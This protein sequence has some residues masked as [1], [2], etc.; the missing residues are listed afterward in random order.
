MRT[1]NIW[2][3]SLFL[4]AVLFAT[5]GAS[6]ALA[7]CGDDGDDGGDGMMDAGLQFDAGE[8]DGGPPDTASVRVVHAA[9]GAGAV[10]LYLGGTTSEPLQ[11]GFDYRDVLGPIDAPRNLSV[12]VYPAGADAASMDPIFTLNATFAGGQSYTVVVRARDDGSLVAPSFLDSTIPDAASGEVAARFV[13]ATTPAEPFSVDTDFDGNSDTAETQ[14]GGAVDAIFA[15]DQRLL[16]VFDGSRPVRR[17]ANFL[18]DEGFLPGAGSV[19]FIGTGDPTALPES[20]EGFV[21]IY[22]DTETNE[23]QVLLPDVPRARIRVLHASANAPAV[24]VYPAGA[25]GGDPIIDDL[26]Y[27]FATGYLTVRTDVG[28]DIYPGDA[29]PGASEPILAVNAGGA[30]ILDRDEDYTLLAVG[31][32]AGDAPA[33]EAFRVIPVLDEFTSPGTTSFLARI[34][35]ASPQ[36]PTITIDTTGDTEPETDGLALFDSLDVPLPVDGVRATFLTADEEPEALTSFTVPGG[37]LTAGSLVYVVAA[38]GSGAHPGDADALVLLAAPYVAAASETAAAVQLRQDPMVWGFHGVP[39]VGAAVN[40]A[41]VDADGE[42]VVE[43]TG[44]TFGDLVGRIQASPGDYTFEVRLGGEPVATSDAVSVVAGT[45]YLVSAVGLA[46]PDTA[47]EENPDPDN[48]IE[49]LVLEDLFDRTDAANARVR[50]VHAS[51]DGAGVEVGTVDGSGGSDVFTAIAAFGTLTYRTSATDAGVVIAP[52]DVD[53]GVQDV[54]TPDP[55]P[56]VVFDGVSLVAGGRTFL[57]AAGE[58]VP[59]AGDSIVTLF[60]VET[61][62]GPW[63]VESYDFRPPVIP[64]PM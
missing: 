4:P 52:G 45:R 64:P 1:G 29:D 24:D 61:G 41:V 34:V 26:A 56:T 39:D 31:N 16:G 58:F 36:T 15:S 18:L 51:P 7:G 44:V 12:D 49:F 25:T 59:E 6:M 53:L 3:S 54:V 40:L 38:G 20:P 60:A 35:H 43:A 55:I 10:D 57:I 28:V 19:Y 14:Q 8:P 2:H 22:V 62:A 11:A 5:L 32:P 17:L 27:G 13:N 42:D 30:E 63:T 33:A 47:A 9:V 21:F 23:S 46:E 48:P 37:A 50:G